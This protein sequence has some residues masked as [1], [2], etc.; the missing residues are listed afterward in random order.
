M[1]PW[2]SFDHILPFIELAKVIARRGHTISFISTPRNIDRLHNL[3]PILS[4]LIPLVKLPLSPVKNLPPNAEETSD[5]EVNEFGYLKRV[6][7]LLQQP[8]CQYL[9]STSPHLDFIVCDYAAF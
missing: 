8:L 5:L 7:D 6:Y 3:P 2:L 1:F 9:R 4:S